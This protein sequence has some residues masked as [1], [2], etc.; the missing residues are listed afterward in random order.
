MNKKLVISISVVIILIIAIIFLLAR[1]GSG[2]TLGFKGRISPQAASLIAQ[3]NGFEAD[4]DFVQAKLI[5]QKLIADFPSSRDLAGWQKKIDSLNVGAIA[6]PNQV[7]GWSVAYEIKPGDSLFK[8]A[9]KFNTTVELIRKCNNFASDRIVPGQKI[10]VVNMPFK[11]FVDKSQNI[12]LLKSNDEVIKTYIVSTGKNN[13]S[14]VGTFKIT[15]K[16]ENPT[17]FKAGAVIPADS[18]ENILGSRWMGFDLAGYGIHGT[19]EPNNLGK[20]VTQGCVRMAN[21][22][23][24]ELYMIV[25]AGTE[26]TIVD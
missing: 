22:D 5:Y 15:T 25:P 11:I 2:T 26:V 21:S 7:E 6:S 24:E 18:P 14:P 1:K 19:T 17:W 8:I 16:L 10:K 13:S 4:K 3:A 23:V 20:Q 9:K 12:L